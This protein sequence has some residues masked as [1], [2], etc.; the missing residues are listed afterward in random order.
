MKHGKATQEQGSGQAKQGQSKSL[1]AVLE[2]S[3]QVSFAFR[4]SLADFRASEG[5]HID[6]KG[7]SKNHKHQVESI[8]SLLKKTLIKLI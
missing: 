1:G 2:Q 7:E 4:R 8:V 6:E 5:E 3:K